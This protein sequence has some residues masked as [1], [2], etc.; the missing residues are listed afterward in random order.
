MAIGHRIGELFREAARALDDG[1]RLAAEALLLEA[2][3]ATEEFEATADS[4]R[5][6]RWT[7]A[8]ARR[9][10]AVESQLGGEH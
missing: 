8:D 10:A 5:W 6:L 9:L 3:D 7:A 1:R 2:R 4:H